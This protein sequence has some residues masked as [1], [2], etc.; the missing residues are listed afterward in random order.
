MTITRGFITRE[1]LEDIASAIRVKDASAPKEMLPSEMAQAILDIPTGNGGNA[2][3]PRFLKHSDLFDILVNAYY[4]DYD[5]ET[6]SWGGLTITGTPTL[7]PRG[8]S[9]VKG[10]G[11]TYQL[12]ELNHNVTVYAIVYS[13]VGD[14]AF[15]M[16][17]GTRET[18]GYCPNI[19]A[20]S[21]KWRK[22]SWSDTSINE[23]NYNNVSVLTMSIDVDNGVANFYIDGISQGTVTIYESGDTVRFNGSI[24]HNSYPGGFTYLYI[25]I[26]DGCEESATILANQADMMQFLQKA[27]VV[28][29]TSGASGNNILFGAES[30][31]SDVGDNGSIYLLTS[32]A[33]IPANTTTNLIAGQNLNIAYRAFDNDDT[34]FWTTSD[35][36]YNDMYIGYDNGSPIV[37]SAVSINP[38]SWANNVQVG[39]FK[40]QASNDLS[41]WVDLAEFT[42]PNEPANYAG[43][44]S[45]FNFNNTTAY[46]AYRVLAI[47]LNGS[48]TFTLFGLQF[49]T[50]SF[51][52]SIAGVFLKVNDAW[53]PIVGQFISN[54]NLDGSGDDDGIMNSINS[55]TSYDEKEF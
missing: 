36:N 30:P 42:V 24:S 33:L 40:V 9:V 20:K 27:R 16:S 38:R 49:Y 54:V 19:N 6:P 22:S 10:Q 12:E 50:S 7:E 29:P 44:W 39:N 51:N 8:I 23:S 53:V 21:D 43:K 47:T 25:G 18:T 48:V 26:V 28:E 1:Y 17:V 13:R 14:S 15:V 55:I 4:T 11:F 2:I 52:D 31:T 41:T 34:T 37:C 32:S 45:M 35:N 3:V 46:R 5:S